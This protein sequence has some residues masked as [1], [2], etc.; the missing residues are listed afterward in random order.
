MEYVR[1]SG[2][3]G[4]KEVNSMGGMKKTCPVCDGIGYT[5]IAVKIEKK[6]PNKK[7]SGE[8]LQCEAS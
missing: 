4:Q 8:V 1:C 6:K 5:E 3:R 7:V 2:C